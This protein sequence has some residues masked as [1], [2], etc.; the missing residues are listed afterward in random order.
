MRAVWAA[1]K[2]FFSTWGLRI[3][4]IVALALASYV[5]WLMVDLRLTKAALANSNAQLKVANATIE[6]Q[7]RAI[8]ALDRVDE[9]EQNLNRRLNALRSELREAEG[10]SEQ[11]P[12]AVAA[13][14]AAGI[15]SLRARNSDPGPAEGLP[16]P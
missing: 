15:D 8:A 1:V 13:V 9:L 11:V 3:A 12:P 2:G 4:V 5:G 6:A 10:S 14:W 7:Q 16:S